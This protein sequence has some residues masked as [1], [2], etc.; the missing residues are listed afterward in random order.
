[1]RSTFQALWTLALAVLTLA[2]CLGSGDSEVTTY[3]D[4]VVTSFTLGTLN[5]CIH[6]TSTTGEDSTYWASV[7]GSYY[8]M[9]IDHLGQKIY[10]RDSLPEGTDVAHVIC[11]ITTRN[12]G[13]AYF[14]SMQ[15]DTLWY[16]NAEDSLDFSQP[17]LLRIYATD[18]SGS[19][20]YTV[21]LNVKKNT[22]QGIAWTSHGTNDSQWPAVDNTPAERAAD[23]GLRLVG[24]SS[25]EL[26]ALTADNTALMVSADNGD[27]W[28]TE[29]L[30]TDASLLP[31]NNVVSV[32]WPFE[33]AD[34]ADYT[35]LIGLSQVGG[36]RQVVWRKIAEYGGDSTQ[37]TGKWVYMVPVEDNPFGLPST[38]EISV[39]YYNGTVLA[40]ASNGKTYQSRD[41]GITWKSVSAYAMPEGISGKV[42][43]TV[44]ANGTVW[45]KS[46]E[47]GQVWSGIWNE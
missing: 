16:Y 43:A 37:P 5:R 23:K 29:T 2:S 26:Y 24:Q 33:Y 31:V 40:F 6:T 15:S 39:V 18:G 4:V 28:T 35:L 14:K 20:D 44:D 10:N 11:T 12:N 21:T 38:V 25:K 9:T 17:R 8:P 13:V 30:D 1:M 36:D 19:R 32:T 34:N 42:E 27:T 45:L 41:K 3:D 22:K 47:T 7:T 46:V